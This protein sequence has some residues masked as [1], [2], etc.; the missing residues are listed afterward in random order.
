[1]DDSSLLEEYKELGANIRHSGTHYGVLVGVFLAVTGWLISTEFGQNA[2]NSKFVSFSLKFV[3]LAM[4][5]LFWVMVES[6][7]F[8][9]RHYVQ[10]AAQIEST[11]GYKQYSTLP[12]APEFYIRPAAWAART[13]FICV[14][15]FWFVT[16]FLET[17]RP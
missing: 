5:V 14:I 2:S 4:T 8:L 3:G 6:A 11:T 17:G 16:F 1:M 10:R 13:L 15:I 9:W 7:H 12:G